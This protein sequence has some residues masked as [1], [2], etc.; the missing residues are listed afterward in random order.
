MTTEI[1]A[2][3]GQVQIDQ[4]EANQLLYAVEGNAVLQA[5]ATGDPAQ[6]TCIPVSLFVVVGQNAAM[7]L[8]TVASA[9][10]EQIPPCLKKWRFQ[11]E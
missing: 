5:S 10:E 7:S 8:V 4:Q 11:Y 3:E 1:E 6:T 2:V 9:D